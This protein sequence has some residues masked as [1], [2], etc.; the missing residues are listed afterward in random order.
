MPAST[1]FIGLTAAAVA[2]CAFAVPAQAQSARQTQILDC[3]GLGTVAITAPQTPH[4]NWSAAQLTGGG[5]LVPVSFTYRVTDLTLG[6][7]L[8]EETVEHGSAHAHQSTIACEQ[9]STGTLAELLPAPP[10]VQLPPDAAPTDAIE[11]AFIA[12][13]VTPGG[14]R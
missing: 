5:N 7:V 12:T 4:D 3:E 1:R 11:L 14:N 2:V 8:D 10:G 13:A 9:T 6:V